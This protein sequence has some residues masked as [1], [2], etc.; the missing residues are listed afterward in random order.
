MSH[1]NEAYRSG[2]LEQAIKLYT[3]VIIIDSQYAPAYYQR[4]MAYAKSG[5]I[6]RESD[7][8]KQVLALTKEPLLTRDS[9]YNLGLV[10]EKLGEYGRAVEWYKK[11]LDIDP[12]FYKAL[13]NTGSALIRLTSMELKTEVA[14]TKLT[15]A[16]E[17]LKR[18]LEFEPRD[19]ISYWNLAIAHSQLDR[20]DDV[21]E[22]LSA[23]VRLTSPDDPLH[24]IAESILVKEQDYS[25][26]LD[27]ER[28][29][30][31]AR[32]IERIIAANNGC[33]FEEALSL[34]NE[35]MSTNLFAAAQMKNEVVWDE[36]AY[37]L[38]RLERFEEAFK[39]CEEGIR[40]NPDS[41]RLYY[42]KA[43]ILDYW[44]RSRE[45]LSNYRKYVEL[46]P[47][48]YAPLVEKVKI[49]MKQ[50]EQKL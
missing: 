39:C 43:D 31:F 40:V 28:Q 26:I 24:K 34:C 42:T 41:A 27:V 21:K 46:A 18:A 23:F 15:H 9:Y 50:L 38:V 48:E 30:Q 10:A 2:Q 11:A 6:K 16:I 4:G 33:A 37:A 49:R 44:G 14:E 29:R 32:L 5:D 19:A 17:Y 35:A 12:G 7:D 13:C 36:K 3:D 22:D 8:F 45:A 1:A 20:T 47:V 25:A